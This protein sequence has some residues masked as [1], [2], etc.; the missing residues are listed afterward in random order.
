MPSFTASEFPNP[1]NLQIV[2]KSGRLTVA[3]L[4][5][6]SD[7][8]I[9]GDPSFPD[10][11]ADGVKQYS[12]FYI[13]IFNQ[14]T[15]KRIGNYFHI[16]PWA[17]LSYLRR[18]LDSLQPGR[19]I[20][21][22]L[23]DD[24]E[25]GLPQ[26][27]RDLLQSLGSMA[28]GSIGRGM[29]WGWLWVKGGRTLAETLTFPTEEKTGARVLFMSSVELADEG[30]K[31]AS[32]PSLRSSR[33]Q[34]TPAGFSS[35]PIFSL[36]TFL[37]PHPAG[38]PSSPAGFSSSPT[39]ALPPHPP[40]AGFSLLRRVSRVSPGG[41]SSGFSLLTHPPR[42]GE[43]SQWCPQWPDSEPWQRRRKFCSKYEQYGD[44]CSCS[45][46]NL[47]DFP[48]SKIENSQIE[49]AV[50]VVL[51]HRVP[52][53]YKSLKTVAAAQGFNRSR[54]EV[55][56]PAPH[57]ELSEFLRLVGLP[58][59]V[60][61][62][63]SEFVA[64]LI[65]KQFVFMI[66]FVLRKYKDADLL[67]FLEEDVSV[68]PDFFMSVDD[69]S[70]FCVSA[71]ND[72][73]YPQTSYD[74]RAVLRAESYTNYGWMVT[75][76]F[77]AE[78][79]AGM[80]HMEMEFDWDI[81]TFYYIRGNRE[82][83]I[84]EVSRSHHFGQSGSHI[85]Q[86]SARVLFSTKNF[87]QD[88]AALVEGVERLE[89]HTYENHITL[90][91]AKAQYIN[92]EETNPCDADFLERF[93]SESEVVYAIFF[94]GEGDIHWFRISDAWTTIARCLGVFSSDVR[95]GH[96]GLYR[97]RL[98]AAHLLLVAHPVS[99]YSLLKPPDLP[100]FRATPSALAGAHRA[101][102]KDLVRDRYRLEP[103]EETYR[104]LVS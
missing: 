54:F 99:P 37:P 71:H 55:F 97:M 93:S 42:V 53:L 70:L 81:Y 10:I 52:S 43:A 11:P 78:M 98:G 35:S 49:K 96:R 104:R 44:L 14:W 4:T 46:P 73:S 100:V 89:K 65:T 13:F 31:T 20:L 56:T 76:S 34:P 57:P 25:Y 101:L 59:T 22:V 32:T 48:D 72:L 68:S 23:K 3:A 50:I 38:S 61:H 19:I 27:I 83:I 30:G 28:A 51:A 45:S 9:P 2:G 33:T 21:F 82:C 1:R 62:E 39:P 29:L 84:P 64:T 67:I 16:Q 6:Y 90:L 92:V 77:A 91:L 36:L 40:P 94:H 95:E 24:L 85:S 5:N 58:L 86:Y 26:E 79:A 103:P 7:I 87:N 63:D 74:P 66:E 15:G 88:P 18:F 12:G 8:Q 75:R 60:T 69:P 47:L 102:T 17:D 41:F 80:A